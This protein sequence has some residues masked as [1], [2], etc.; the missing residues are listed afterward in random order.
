MI[1]DG[2]TEVEAMAR[3]IG[4]ATERLD[5]RADEWVPEAL[6]KV[7]GGDGL[8]VNFRIL[9]TDVNAKIVRDEAATRLGIENAIEE[10]QDLLD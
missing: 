4:N 5:N 3:M 9:M 10:A 7:E 2:E 1:Y 8:I 6:R